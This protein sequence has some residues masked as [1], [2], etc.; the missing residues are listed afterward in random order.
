MNY[1]RRQLFMFYLLLASCGGSGWVEHPFDGPWDGPNLKV[2]EYRRTTQHQMFGPDSKTRILWTV[3]NGNRVSPDTILTPLVEH[4][5]GLP[6]FKNWPESQSNFN[7]IQQR[8]A[9][10]KFYLVAIEPVVLVALPDDFRSLD[11]SNY[12]IIGETTNRFF[13]NR[14]LL[15]RIECATTIP[16][17]SQISWCS[18]D[19]NI[20]LTRLEPLNENTI[21]IEDEKVRLVLRKEGDVWRVTRER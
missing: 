18:S 14:Y 5:K 8:V 6:E 2:K 19:L 9:P 17:H 13:S 12:E 7:G 10:Y 15:N 16:F 1:F 3:R 4:L 11:R 21:K 20:Q